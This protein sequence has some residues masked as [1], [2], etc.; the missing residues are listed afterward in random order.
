MGLTDKLD[1]LMRERNINKAVLAREAGIPYTTIDGFYKKGSDNAK[2]STLKKLCA[3]FGCT[4]DFLADDSIEKELLTTTTP[5]EEEILKKYRCLD[6]ET[7]DMINSVVE[8]A[9][10]MSGDRKKEP[11]ILISQT[12][13]Y[14]LDIVK[15]GNVIHLL[16][17]NEQEKSLNFLIKEGNSLI[18]SITDNLTINDVDTLEIPDEI[19]I[20]LKKLLSDNSFVNFNE[21]EASRF[22]SDFVLAVAYKDVVFDNAFLHDIFVQ[23]HFLSSR[24]ATEDRTK[25]FYN[26]NILNAAHER[27]DIET[28]EEMKQHDDAYFDEED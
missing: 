24:I 3:Y 4:L 11:Q 22:I 10:K 2:L 14:L 18:N 19:N 13:G 12:P 16:K 6:Q 20:L 8:N 7:K 25:Y 5:S 28:T 9:Y 1:L 15:D 17:T 23:C 21:S 26:S 27:N